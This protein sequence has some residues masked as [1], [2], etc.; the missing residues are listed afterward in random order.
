[1]KYTVIN[2]VREWEDG[3]KRELRLVC[4]IRLFERL[5]KG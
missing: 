1:M 4:K 5:K 2:K 3:R